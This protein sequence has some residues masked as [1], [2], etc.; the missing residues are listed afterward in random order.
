MATSRPNAYEKVVNRLLA[1]PH[2]GERWARH[3]LDL[4][5]FAETHGHEFDF[6]IPNAYRYRDYVIR[7][8]N[9]DLPYDQFVIEH[10]AGDLLTQ[11]RRNSLD[12]TNDSII[13]T[14]WYFFGE[15]VHSPVDVRADEAIRVD[16]QI[17]VF[18]KTFL[19]LT[20]SCARCHDHKFDAISTKD[21]Y[22]LAGYLQSSRYQQAPIDAPEQLAPVL[23]Q[24]AAV[25][26]ERRQLAMESGRQIA[27]QLPKIPAALQDQV[28]DGGDPDS[29]PAADV[30]HAWHKL[31]AQ[32]DGPTLDFSQRRSD[33]VREMTSQ[34][35]AAE[36]ACTHPA[37]FVGTGTAA[38]Q[39]SGAAF[40]RG[41]GKPLDLLPDPTNQ[42]RSDPHSDRAHGPLGLAVR[43]AAR[44]VAIAYL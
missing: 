44:R 20:V 17:D 19:G 8:I 37:A 23:G 16:N 12:G 38:W 30:V 41:L 15:A 39:A 33:L 36:A 27:Q 26:S 7:A 40:S 18:S 43:K 3:W 35:T 25:K 31:N 10:V 34:L 6:D 9:A 5:R 22:A 11:P 2:Y 4:V 28:A 1:S 32:T 42:R 24:L 13:A 29:F 14:G 21:Y